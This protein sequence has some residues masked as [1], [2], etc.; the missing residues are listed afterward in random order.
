[1]RCCP[2]FQQIPA[3]LAAFDGRDRSVGDRNAIQIRRIVL[4]E[5][6]QQQ[7][8]C[9]AVRDDGDFRP[10]TIADYV[11]PGTVGPFLQAAARFACGMV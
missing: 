5:L 10:V 4:E 9:A 7:T 2:D 6:Q 11:L 1:M 8:N 3:V